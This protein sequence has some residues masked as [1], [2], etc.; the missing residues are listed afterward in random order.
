MA[1][2]PSGLDLLGVSIL[3]LRHR[4][5][6]NATA[7]LSFLIHWYRGTRCRSLMRRRSVVRESGQKPKRPLR[8]DSAGF[9]Y[10]SGR[11]VFKIAVRTCNSG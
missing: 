6:L 1:I 10:R 9:L 11:E 7:T 3:A 2:D 4:R 5:T 8:S